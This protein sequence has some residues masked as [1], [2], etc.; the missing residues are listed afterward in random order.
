MAYF[1]YKDIILI[2]YLVFGG[3]G[4]LSGGRGVLRGGRGVLGGRTVSGGSV[5]LGAGHGHGQAGGEGYNLK[6]GIQPSNN[7]Q[8][9]LFFVVKIIFLLTFTEK[10]SDFFMISSQLLEAEAWN[11]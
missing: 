11:S 8:I 6:N 4:V 3:R 5:G 7:L 9:N 1:H 2:M 10:C